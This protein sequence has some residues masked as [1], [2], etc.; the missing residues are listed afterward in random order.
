MFEWRKR[1]DWRVTAGRSGFPESLPAW[2]LPGVGSGERRFGVQ[3]SGVE[4]EDIRPASDRGRMGVGILPAY[5]SERF[6][7]RGLCW[8]EQVSCESRT[9]VADRRSCF[10]R[11]GW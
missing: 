1:T 8:S 2:R 5:W 10:V 7:L 11:G 3:T 9:G 4:E 6:L